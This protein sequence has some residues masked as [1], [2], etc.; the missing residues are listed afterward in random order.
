M[1]AI[2]CQE[3]RIR[4]SRHFSS[5]RVYLLRIIRQAAESSKLK[6]E[7]DSWGLTSV[8]VRQLT[9]PF[10]QLAQLDTRGWRKTVYIKWN[11]QRILDVQ[12]CHCGTVPVT[13]GSGRKRELFIISLWAWFLNFTKSVPFALPRLSGLTNGCRAFNSVSFIGHLQMC[14]FYCLFNT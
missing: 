4:L 14:S 11:S 2:Y 10:N 5:E 12:Q 9:Y 3:S 8:T 13:L 1:T 6:S 7:Q